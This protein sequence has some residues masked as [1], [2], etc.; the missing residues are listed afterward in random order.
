MSA[1]YRPSHEDYVDACDEFAARC[2]RF[3]LSARQLADM[4][5]EAL[6]ARLPLGTWVEPWRADHTTEPQYLIVR[7]P[8]FP[9]MPLGDE[10]WE[11]VDTALACW[12]GQEVAQ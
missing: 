4:A 8:G 2:R 6:L 10:E 3:G 11:I 1:Y 5:E 12:L 9:W 7:T